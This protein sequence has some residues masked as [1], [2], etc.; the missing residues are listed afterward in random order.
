MN[1]ATIIHGYD[2]GVCPDG[3]PKYQYVDNIIQ[4]MEDLG[5]SLDTLHRAWSAGAVSYDEYKQ[6]IEME[7]K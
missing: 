2:F 3:L 1:G 6:L 7:K 4:L 5:C